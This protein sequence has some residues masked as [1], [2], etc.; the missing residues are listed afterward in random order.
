MTQVNC[1]GVQKEGW[2]KLNQMVLHFDDWFTALLVVP[3]FV[4]LIRVNISPL[5]HEDTK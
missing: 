5:N 2:K 1:V 3:D 4:T